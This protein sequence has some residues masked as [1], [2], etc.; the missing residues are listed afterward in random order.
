MEFDDFPYIGNFIIPT[1][2]YFSEG[3]VYHQPAQLTYFWEFGGPHDPAIHP[4]VPS[5]LALL[6]GRQFIQKNAGDAPAGRNRFYPI[7]F[8]C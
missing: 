3:F 2:E 7:A 4:H 5:Q 1:D 8:H 6:Y